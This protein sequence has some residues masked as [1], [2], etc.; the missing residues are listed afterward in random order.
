LALRT[1]LSLPFARAGGP[2]YQDRLGH[3][4]WPL[5][6]DNCRVWEGGVWGLISRKAKDAWGLTFW[7]MGGDLGLA[8]AQHVVVPRPTSENR[9]PTG[10]KRR[11]RTETDKANPTV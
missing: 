10:I 1:W 11:R 8:T 3:R 4:V 6:A 9:D 2:V 5:A 7:A